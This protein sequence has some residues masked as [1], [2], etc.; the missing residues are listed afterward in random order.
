[1]IIIKKPIRITIIII[2][3]FYIG[4]YQSFD[5][6][7]FTTDFNQI[8]KLQ[9]QINTYRNNN[10]E[11]SLEN[12][13]VDLIK[14]NQLIEKVA[15]YISLTLSVDTTNSIALKY[16]DQLDNL[17]ASFVEDE[18]LN[19]Q[20]ISTFKLDSLKSNL[21]KEHLFI[22][23]EIQQNQKYTLDKKSESII[24][25]MQNT[26]SNAFSKLKDQ[27]ISSIEVTIEDQ[28]Y[29]LTS[30]LNMAYDKDREIRKKAYQA[31]INSYQDKEQAIAACLN[32]IKGEVLYTTKLRGYENE[33]E[34][35]LINARMS[36]ETL[37]VLL[38]VMQENLNVFRDY[39]K[40]KATALGYQNGLP[41]FEL[42]APVIEDHDS[43]PYEKSCQ[44]IINQFS[45]FSEHLGTFAKKAIENNWIDVYPQSGKVGGAFCCNLHSIKESRFLL[46]YGDSFSDA[47]TMAH[48]LGHGFHGEC[49]N[50]ESILNS[51]YP[52]PIAETA[53]TFCETIVTKAA[54]KKANDQ[55][56][57]SLLEDELSGATQVI[58]DIYSRYLFESRFFEKRE[59][60][61]LSVEEIKELMIQAQKDAYGDGLDHQYLHPYMWTWKPHYY[62]ADCSFY[63]FPYAFGLL[64]AKGLYTIYQK[65]GSKFSNTYEKLLSLTGKMSLEDVCSSVNINLKDKSFWQASIN[66]FKED[67]TL[68]K[69][70]LNKD[71]ISQ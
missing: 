61:A 51:D 5:D 54:L 20:W 12:Y 50:D 45:T 28:T 53:S 3:L 27:L 40:T 18:V 68:Y 22:L 25:H 2:V 60:G 35:T 55:T 19:Q 8:I 56:K 62:Y 63:N 58:V 65:E 10:D 47:I 42:Y 41:W 32:G 69:Q 37:D 71:V 49:L 31:E 64:L 43:H 67:L 9:K 29:P 33:L 13:L 30:V 7:S 38:T 26:G 23:K 52:M 24:A 36:K 14:L 66:T 34:R 57:L 48:E 1:M 15:N 70:L 21:I 16:S 59:T 4:L 17:L 39:L 46:N 44:F 6:S 11:K